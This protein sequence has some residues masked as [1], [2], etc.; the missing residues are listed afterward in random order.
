M[1]DEFGS[2]GIGSIWQQMD[3]NNGQGSNAYVSSWDPLN[4][5]INS[6]RS[7]AISYKDVNEGNV[8]DYLRS[9]NDEGSKDYYIKYLLD[10]LFENDA[11]AYNAQREDT[12]YQRMV[13]DLKKAGISPYALSPSGSPISSASGFNASGTSYT[14]AR[15]SQRSSDTSIATT[16]MSVMGSVLSA[17]G[18]L[19]MMLI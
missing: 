5:Y 8:L 9:Q 3:Q 17:L 2:A 12:Y 14:S 7:S 15:N 18:F 10:K 4:A 6:I 1:A 13:E 11:R 16:A 19:A